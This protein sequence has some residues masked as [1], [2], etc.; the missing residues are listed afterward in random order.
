MRK[1][2]HLIFIERK[3]KIMNNTTPYTKNNI[4]VS[5]P[6]FD[7]TNEIFV[8]DITYGQSVLPLKINNCKFKIQ[9]IRSDSINAII[10]A[11]FVDSEF[12]LYE[13]LLQTDR[14]IFESIIDNSEVWFGF[15]S[16]EEKV[17]QMCTL[18]INLPEK[19]TDNPT[20]SVIVQYDSNDDFRKDDLINIDLII[21]KI[22]FEKSRFSI[23]IVGD[24]MR[25][26]NRE[27]D[28]LANYNNYDDNND[29]SS[30]SPLDELS[31][32][33]LSE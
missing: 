24:N 2:R 26:L 18:N 12:K 28:N 11:E 21:S 14:C 5:D 16:S 20:L 31:C 32:T 19:L 25:L 8:S 4:N 23:P 3:Y 17:R 27:T 13:F 33:S 7:E 15:A 1:F 30:E 29:V 6:I 22:Y 9:T 10:T